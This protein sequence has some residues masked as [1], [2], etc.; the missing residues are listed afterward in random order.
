M[1][2]DGRLDGYGEKRNVEDRLDGFDGEI[3]SLDIGCLNKKRFD[4]RRVEEKLEEKRREREK[5]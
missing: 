3:I 1:Q 2:T 5:I 4:E